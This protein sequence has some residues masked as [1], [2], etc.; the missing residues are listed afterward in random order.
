MG[1]TPSGRPEA[2]V[3]STCEGGGINPV[4]E[5]TIILAL[6]SLVLL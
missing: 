2:R 3:H 6:L 5:L 4:A 1:K